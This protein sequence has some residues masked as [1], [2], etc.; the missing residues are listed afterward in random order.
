MSTKENTLQL[1]QFPSISSGESESE[2]EYSSF[3]KRRKHL[4]ENKIPLKKVKI[5]SLNDKIWSSSFFQSSPAHK[6]FPCG[7]DGDLGCYVFLKTS[8]CTFPK[9]FW[10]TL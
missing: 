6:T 1:P 2:T 7:F 9:K 10:C 8:M 4:K 5:K 3:G